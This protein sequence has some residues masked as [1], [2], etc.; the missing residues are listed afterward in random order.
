MGSSA[1]AMLCLHTGLTLSS[2]TNKLSGIILDS[3]AVDLNM[4][5][6]SFKEF[7]EGYFLDS[8]SVKLFVNMYFKNKKHDF[9]ES[10]MSNINNWLLIS[11]GLDPLRDQSFELEKKL[12]FHNCN[13]NHH[14]FKDQLHSFHSL[15]YSYDIGMDKLPHLEIINEFINCHNINNEID[16]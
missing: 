14:H 2:T 13:V 3:P 7:N 10:Q 4:E 15:Y 11:C 12:K 8:K 9:E 6:D 5:L 1:G 16:S